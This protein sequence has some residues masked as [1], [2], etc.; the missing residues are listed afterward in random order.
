MNL[1]DLS[2]EKAKHIAYLLNGFV[3]ETLSATE[4]D[5]LVKWVSAD[6]YNSLLFD[7]ITNPQNIE[8]MKEESKNI[9]G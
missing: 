2:D 1:P 7:Q 5:E 9:P 4:M 6:K 3:T 8:Q